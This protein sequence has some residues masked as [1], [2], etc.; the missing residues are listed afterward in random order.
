[1]AKK[2]ADNVNAHCDCAS[3]AYQHVPGHKGT[4]DTHSILQQPLASFHC[5]EFLFSTPAGLQSS[6]SSGSLLTPVHK[7]TLG[8]L[9][10]SFRA[11]LSPRA[12]ALKNNISQGCSCQRA[13]ELEDA[14]RNQAAPSPRNIFSLS[15]RILAPL[16]L[17]RL[18]LSAC[19]RCTREKT[20]CI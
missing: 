7:H 9:T 20:F 16:C 18:P 14:E 1:M 4:A 8:L 6:S 19:E 17:E 5:S 10:T 11:G 13:G 3:L 15:V 2:G 12:V